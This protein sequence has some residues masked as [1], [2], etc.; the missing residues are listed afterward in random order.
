MSSD[1]D[2]DKTGYGSPPKHTRWKDG[3]KR[4]PRTPISEARGEHG[5]VDRQAPVKAGRDHRGREVA[6]SYHT[7]SDPLSALPEGSARRR[8][9][10]KIR[11]KYEE[12]ARQ[13]SKARS[14]RP[15]FVD[16][17][18]TEAFAAVPQMRVK[19]D[20]DDDVGLRKASQ[21]FALQT[22][23][24]CQSDRAAQAQ[25]EPEAIA[26]II[27]NV[28]NGLAEYRER[29]RAKKAKR[30]E[31]TIKTHTKLAL[32]GNLKSIETMLLL[33]AHAQASGDT[34]VTPP[35]DYRL[36]ARL[37]WPDRRAKDP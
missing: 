14:P 13:N 19:D 1:G 3:P 34:G 23:Q 6:K 17:E 35:R 7:R 21:A 15:S 10:L 28:L 31:L 9:A 26:D 33:R 32:G 29:G 16:N 27:D 4:Q 8:T 5:R 22:G 11:L 25:A 12:F 2:D 36:V 18:Y 24:Q 37:S 20:D 30:R